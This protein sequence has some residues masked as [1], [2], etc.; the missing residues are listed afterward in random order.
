MDIV[1]NFFLNTTKRAFKIIRQIISSILDVFKTLFDNSR[2]MEERINAA[3]K[4]ISAALVGVSAIILEEAISNALKSIPPLAPFADYISPVLAA[5]ITGIGGVLIL[6]LFSKYQSEFEYQKLTQDAL[7]KRGQLNNLEIVESGIS[8]AETA[9]TINAS[10]SIFENTCYIVSACEKDI[11][12]A[13]DRIEAGSYK[14]AKLLANTN[15][16]LNEIDKILSLIN[17]Q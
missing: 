9:E 16:N 2:P 15:E 1:I 8:E 5:L 3:L 10:I 11:N 6:Q 14:R 4:I 13:I 12:Y 7:I 17:K